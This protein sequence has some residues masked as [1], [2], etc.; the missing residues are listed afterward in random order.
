MDFALTPSE[1][2]HKISPESSD[3]FASVGTILPKEKAALLPG[4]LFIFPGG[5]LDDL[6]ACEE[7]RYNPTRHRSSRADVAQL[8]EQLIR[9]QQVIG[10]SPIVGSSFRAKSPTHSKPGAYGW[11][12]GVNTCQRPLSISRSLPDR[13]RSCMLTQ[14]RPKPLS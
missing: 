3:G 1:A 8:V 10:S 13:C 7:P 11:R 14:N 4:G 9:N 6:Y 12:S 2:N 5:E